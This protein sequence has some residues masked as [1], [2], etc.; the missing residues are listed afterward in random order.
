MMASLNDDSIMEMS[1]DQSH[2]EAGKVIFT[3]RCVLCH[4]TDLSGTNPDGVKLPGV[5]LNDVEWR[6]G[7]KPLEI[8]KTITNGPP[9]T[10]PDGTPNPQLGMVAW[11]NQISPAKIAQVV[12]YILSEQP[13]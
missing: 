13:K 8:M 7:G 12:A 6:Y 4:G 10:K 2:V 5:P 11:N 3:T 1:K 9:K